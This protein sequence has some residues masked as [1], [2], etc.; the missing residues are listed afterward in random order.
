MPMKRGY[1][2]LKHPRNILK[3]KVEEYNGPLNN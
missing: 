3:T 2:N 1:K